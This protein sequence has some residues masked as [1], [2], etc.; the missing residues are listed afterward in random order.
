M[1]SRR[2][3]NVIPRIIGRR[4]VLFGVRVWGFLMMNTDQYIEKL[5]AA[6]PVFS[7]QQRTQLAELLKPVR[8]NS[9]GFEDTSAA[10]S[11]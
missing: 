2:F 3:G 10:G 1:R 9:R 5:I 11:A 4:S 8:V 7:D 6:W